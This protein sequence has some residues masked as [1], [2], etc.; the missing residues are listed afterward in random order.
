MNEN[1]GIVC[2]G[3]AWQRGRK[4]V[5][6]ACSFKCNIT[7]FNGNLMSKT[8]SGPGSALT[9]V[10]IRQQTCVLC[11]C[12]AYM[13]KYTRTYIYMCVCECVETSDNCRISP[14]LGLFKWKD[15]QTYILACNR[16]GGKVDALPLPPSARIFK[17]ELLFCPPCALP[18]PPKLVTM[19]ART[20]R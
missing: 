1:G 11:L 10:W 4:R 14:F 3:S 17:L 5:N 13:Y 2:N 19:T 20:Q 12:D 8:L 16:V 18:R 6:Y 7:E 15:R 9:Q